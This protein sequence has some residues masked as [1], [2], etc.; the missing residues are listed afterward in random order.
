MDEQYLQRLDILFSTMT[1]GEVVSPA[2][3]D[4]LCQARA[5]ALSE[6]NEGLFNEIDDLITCSKIESTSDSVRI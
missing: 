1:P 4:L 6:G 3:I 2:A 5:A